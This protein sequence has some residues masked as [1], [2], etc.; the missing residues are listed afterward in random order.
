MSL[1][2]ELNRHAILSI[3]ATTLET[4]AHSRTTHRKTHTSARAARAVA[5]RTRGREI[6]DRWLAGVLC[7]GGMM[8]NNKAL[9]SWTGLNL[10]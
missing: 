1:V 7:R 4:T 3:L 9:S 5:K 10:S 8:T 2:M 6:E